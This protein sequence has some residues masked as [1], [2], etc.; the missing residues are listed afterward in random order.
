MQLATSMFRVLSKYKPESKDEKKA[1]LKAVAEA[2]AADA[3]AQPASKKPVVLKY[4]LNHITALVE[5]NKAKLVVIAHDVD[6]IE[7]C[8]SVLLSLMLLSLLCGCPHCAARR[9][10]HSPL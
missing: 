5:Q 9:I 1:R 4:G 8:C 2:K 3:S 7:V 6:P 10:F